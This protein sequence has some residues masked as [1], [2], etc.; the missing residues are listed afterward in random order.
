MD[1]SRH[2]H[3]LCH[4]RPVTGQAA[5]RPWRIRRRTDAGFQRQHTRHSGRGTTVRERQPAR[6]R[7]DSRTRHK[8]Q[9]HRDR[10]R[11]YRRKSDQLGQ[12]YH[13]R[14]TLQPYN[15]RLYELP[16]Y[17]GQQHQ[18]HLPLL[19]DRCRQRIA[20]HTRNDRKHTQAAVYGRV[21]NQETSP[22]CGRPRGRRCQPR[23]S[24]RRHTRHEPGH[25]QGL[26]QDVAR[27]QP[28]YQP[29]QRLLRVYT[30]TDS[31]G[32][33]IPGLL[34]Y[35]HLEVVPLRGHTGPRL[36][37]PCRDAVG[38]PALCLREPLGPRHRRR[39]LPQ[40]EP[41]HRRNIRCALPL[42]PKPRRP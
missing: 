39:R 1:F 40:L 4:Y 17:A 35:S 24:R 29:R 12:D 38:V 36:R 13:H 16:K 33:S 26:L 18:A 10:G 31:H 2:H 32:H 34:F 22:G 5:C 14:A 11:P 30:R 6:G 19:Y 27:Q 25:V 15:Q 8:C 9:R 3:S 20:R 21:D 28:L 7:L 37:A 42:L 41:R 23:R